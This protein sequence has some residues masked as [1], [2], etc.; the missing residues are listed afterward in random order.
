[1]ESVTY[2]CGHTESI[3][4]TG[5]RK[6]RDYFIKCKEQELCPACQEKEDRQ[7]VEDLK[8]EWEQKG[9]PQ[10][11]GSVKQILWANTLRENQIVTLKQDVEIKAKRARKHPSPEMDEFVAYAD[12]LDECILA[13]LKEH[14]SASSWIEGISL[15]NETLRIYKQRKDGIGK[16]ADEEKPI[17]EPEEM[18]TSAVAE[19][20]LVKAEDGSS[21]IR[22]LSPKDERVISV[23]KEQGLSWRDGAWVQRLTEQNI[24]PEDAQAYLAA[25]LLSAGISVKA[26]LSI[27]NKAI[28]GDYVPGYSRFIFFSD[29]LGFCLRFPYNDECTPM[30]K[31]MGARWDGYHK[32]YVLSGNAWR[33]VQD[34]VNLY[35]FGLSSKSVERMKT[36]SESTFAVNDVKVNERHTE[37]G[38]KAILKSSREILPDLI[39]N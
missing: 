11:L 20:V 36:I 16:K 9:Y 12:Q 22:V 24:S 18:K 17:A 19:L 37:E 8:K 26:E 1:M 35:G 38:L 25:K 6:S 32:C 3:R 15:K 27:L 13:V 30:V 33:S 2:K 5:N 7:A 10:I 31:K 29:T 39:D 14:Q 4:L 23:C 28:S 21:S 34:L